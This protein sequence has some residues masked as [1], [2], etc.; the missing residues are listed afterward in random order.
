LLRASTTFYCLY[1]LYSL[2]CC[3][4]VMAPDNCSEHRAKGTEE[5]FYETGI[6]FTTPTT[7]ATSTTFY[8]L[9]SLYRLYSFLI[10]YVVML[11]FVSRLPSLLLSFHICLFTA[12]RHG[13]CSV[14]LLRSCIL[15]QGW[16]QPGKHLHIH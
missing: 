4:T 11:F 6:P 15:E 14:F 3:L 1:S 9:Y 8:C 16:N 13:L 10:R 12:C 7:F 5:E 2:Y